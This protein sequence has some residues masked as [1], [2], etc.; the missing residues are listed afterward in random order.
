MPPS[1]ESKSKPRKQPTRSKETYRDQPAPCCKSSTVY[2]VTG[3]TTKV[4]FAIRSYPELNEHS[5]LFSNINFNT[6][7]SSVFYDIRWFLAWFIHRTWRWMRHVAPKLRLTFKGLHVIFQKKKLFMTNGVTTSNFIILPSKPRSPKWSLPFGAQG[8][9]SIFHTT[10]KS[11]MR[12][13]I[14]PLTTS[15]HG[16]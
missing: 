15:W 12:G 11:G 8:G 5:T 14:L 16:A 13:A 4:R 6:I 10:P 2:Y 9:T 3:W 1:A 7:K